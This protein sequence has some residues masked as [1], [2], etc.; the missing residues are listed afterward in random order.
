MRMIERRI[1]HTFG[2]SGFTLTEVLA[3]II[4]VSLVSGGLATAVTVG[5]R[6]F[7]QSMA[8]SESKILYSTLEQ[9][10][11]NDLAYTKTFLSYD[12]GVGHEYNVTGYASESHS[13]EK[14]LFLRALDESG[15]SVV[16]P[17]TDEDGKG[18]QDVTGAGQLAL[19]SSDNIEVRNRLINPAAYN[20]GLKAKVISFKYYE[21]KKLFTVNLV[22]VNSQGDYLAGST[23]SVK[24]LNDVGC[25]SSPDTVH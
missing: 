14:P 16:A 2:N 3:T 18:Q 19:C 21:D 10:M 15:S 22:I 24:A 8:L 9:E 7:T 12:S 4:V 17:A 5:S 20:Y 6:Q 23:F 25:L 13:S 1:A 11:K